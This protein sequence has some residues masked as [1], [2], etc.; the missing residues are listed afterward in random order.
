MDIEISTS[1]YN[2]SLHNAL[3]MFFLL[4]TKHSLFLRNNTL[5]CKRNKQID[6][7]LI[8]LAKNTHFLIQ[9]WSQKATFSCRH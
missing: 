8:S 4:I 2:S 1:L 3:T 9:V 5:Y 6:Q 7:T